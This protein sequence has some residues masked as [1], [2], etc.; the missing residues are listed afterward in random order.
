MFVVLFKYCAKSISFTRD[1]NQK[2]IL[3]VN[4]TWYLLLLD[5]RSVYLGSSFMLKINRYTTTLYQ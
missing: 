1:N 3:D 5:N 4:K 2:L